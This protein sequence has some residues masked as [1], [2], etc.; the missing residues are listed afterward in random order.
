[1]PTARLAF[2]TE[3]RRLD[4]ISCCKDCEERH[5]LCHSECERY[6]TE[7]AQRGKNEK[8]WRNGRIMYEYRFDKNTRIKR[9]MKR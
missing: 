2:I 6:I 5:P 1:M 3:L 8:E 9:K 7:K 4:M